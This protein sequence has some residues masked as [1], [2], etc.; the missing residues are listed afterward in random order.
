VEVKSAKGAGPGKAVM[1]GWEIRDEWGQC[2][3]VWS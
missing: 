1:A 3:R 2:R